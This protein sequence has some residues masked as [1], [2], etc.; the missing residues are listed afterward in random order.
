MERLGN[1]AARV[2]VQ[3]FPTVTGF[4]GSTKWGLDLNGNPVTSNSTFQAAILA[5][6]TPNGRNGS[7]PWNS[8]FPWSTLLNKFSSVTQAIY[9]SNENTINSLRSIGVKNILIAQHIGSSSSSVSFTFSTLDTSNSTYWTEAWELYRFS[10]AEA[11]WAWSKRIS[12]IEFCNEPDLQLGSTMNYLQYLQYYFI[13]CLSI[14]NL[15][16]DMNSA[17]PNSQ[18]PVNIVASA[19]ARS[20]FGGDTTQYLGDITVNNNGFMFPNLNTTVPGWRNFHTYS[21]HS[22][23]AS[24]QSMFNTLNQTVTSVNDSSIPVILRSIIL[25]PAQLGT[26]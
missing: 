15:Y 26:H 24:G 21:Y 23:D 13:R 19:F 14:Q 1:N 4:I 18:V 9:G 3:P 17:N 11:Y 8:P 12:L 25:K 2:F 5:L 22:Y 10:Y 16:S 6:R 20:T 7:Y